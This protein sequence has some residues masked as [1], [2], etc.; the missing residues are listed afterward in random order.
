MTL[1][2]SLDAAERSLA[3]GDYK[4]SIKSLEKL[5]HHYPIS[6]EESAKIQLLMVT[7]L[8][9]QG[10]NNKAIEHCKKLAKHPNFSYRQQAKELISILSAPI[11]S[12]PE[13]WS[14]KIPPLQAKN[15]AFKHQKQSSPFKKKVEQLPPT[16]PTQPFKNG[17]PLLVTI[18]LL[19]ITILLSGCVQITTNIDL[20][21]P[22]RLNFAWQIQSNSNQLLPWQVDFSDSL[23]NL[24][25]SVNIKDTNEGSQLITSSKVN[26][27]EANIL[28]QNIVNS[29]SQAAGLNLKPPQISISEKNFFLGARESLEI[30]IDLTELPE[31]PGLKVL[32]VI[33]PLQKQSLLE[34]K[35]PNLVYEDSKLSWE[36]TEGQVNKLKLSYW[37]WSPLGLGV[38]II[39]LITLLTLLIQ[40]TKIQLGFGF[41]ELPP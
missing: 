28:L 21:G 40:K 9:G 30:F 36:L 20:T 35:P 29:A 38:I 18:I 31:I 19:I 7:A 14:V 25:P 33:R 1:E 39:F 32:M 12:K 16:G 22:D 13:N 3:Q 24:T 34:T 17:F 11:L 5:N 10:E 41:P 4:Q 2:E 27:K 23:K 26:S 15:S 37:E 6:S 8:I